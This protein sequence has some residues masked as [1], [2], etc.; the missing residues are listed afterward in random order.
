MSLRVLV[1]LIVAY[2]ALQISVE[3]LL[4]VLVGYAALNV[5]GAML[6]GNRRLRCG[7]REGLF[8]T[9]REIVQVGQPRCSRH[10][11]LPPRIV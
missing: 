2:L 4:F 1:L 6:E 11:G 5:G 10:K 9:C 8:G 3:A 7:A